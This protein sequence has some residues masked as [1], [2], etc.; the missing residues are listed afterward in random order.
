MDGQAGGLGTLILALVDSGANFGV[1]ETK[2]DDLAHRGVRRV[3]LQEPAVDGPFGYER[4][5]VASRH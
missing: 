3:A 2:A 5:S 4:I 1:D